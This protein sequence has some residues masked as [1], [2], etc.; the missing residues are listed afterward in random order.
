MSQHDSDSESDGSITASSTSSDDNLPAEYVEGRVC[1][2]LGHLEA[3]PVTRE[4]T[5]VQVHHAWVRVTDP[6]DHEFSVLSSN[7]HGP[8]FN[9]CY[10]LPGPGNNWL[11]RTSDNTDA[12]TELF[13]HVQKQGIKGHKIHVYQCVHHAQ[14]SSWI[15][16]SYP[17]EKKTKRIP[18][19]EA[20]AWSLQQRLRFEIGD[21]F[22]RHPWN[23]PSKYHQRG[24]ELE[25]MDEDEVADEDERMDTGEDLDED[26]DED[27]ESDDGE[28]EESDDQDNEVSD[29]GEDE[30]SDDEEDG[31]DDEESVPTFGAIWASRA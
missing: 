30:G 4:G 29:D 14:S 17:K 5:L 11:A 28:D 6:N 18:Q 8:R 27:E 9:F 31:E 26:E 10:K 21:T 22:G 2:F 7:P 23:K 19:T 1:H 24:R 12:T 20:L 3:I 25:A 15:I 13:V 16:E